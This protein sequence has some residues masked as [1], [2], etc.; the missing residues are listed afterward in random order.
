MAGGY[1]SHSG[2]AHQG[3]PPSF[4][5]HPMISPFDH[6][7]EEHF[8]SD[9][10][11]FRNI[12]NGYGPG[13]GRY[14]SFLNIDYVRT[15]YRGLNGL[16]GDPNTVTFSQQNTLPNAAVGNAAFD[17]FNNF[18]A[19]NGN[20]I[21][22]L[23]NNGI[24]LSGGV[25]NDEG[26][27][28]EGNV[29]FNGDNT[30]IF[31]S[32]A[33]LQAQRMH[34]STALFLENNG[35]AS[36]GQR[37]T[38]LNVFEREIIENEILNE[39]VFDTTNAETFGSLGSTFDIL[40]RNLYVLHGLPMQNGV[41][42]DG[43]NQIFDLD[44]IMRH[45]IQTYG[46]GGHFVLGKV[47]NPRG[48]SVHPIIGGRYLRVDETFRFDGV[49][50]GLNYTFPIQ[51]GIDDDG[52]FIPDNVF[53]HTGA[54]TFVQ[55]NPSSQ[56]L[57]RSFINSRVRS[58]LAGPEIGVQYA[59]KK[60]HGI[61]INGSTRVGA[62][63]NTE[64]MSLTGDNIGDTATTTVDLT[65]GNTILQDL[66]DTTTTAGATQN[67]FE[68]GQSSTHVSPMFE[69]SLTADVPIFAR[70]P[71]LRNVPILE[72][73][74]LRAG[75]TFLYVGEVADPNQSI[76]WHSNPRQGEFLHLRARRKSFY[77]NSFNFGINWEY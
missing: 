17:F 30:S 21:A 39:R 74:R 24:R 22:T 23:I 16:V 29:G 57:I 34:F 38:L 40:D 2:T 15:N 10:L 12:I 1:P 35:G 32:R 8:N 45:S 19:Q 14:S 42:P 72:G 44:F 48:I 65:T 62:L 54:D 46:A 70:V 36:N 27:G 49:D 31:D 69:Q 71:L 76:V 64:R 50:S 66:F 25:W 63:I 28:F 26:W 4:Q 55:N 51:D 43:F 58:E 75:W 3:I 68:D 5:S 61:N 60:G 20:S 52:D 67:A 7:V 18:D 56:I 53:E 47:L 33:G 73:A 6:A 13:G 77:Q 37:T 59:L 9:G 11:W 41:D